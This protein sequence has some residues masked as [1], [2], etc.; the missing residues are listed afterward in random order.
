AGGS[1]RSPHTL[2]LPFVFATTG[3]AAGLVGEGPEQRLLERQMADAWVAFARTGD[4]NHAGMAPWTPYDMPGRLTMIL[5]SVSRTEPDP[6]ADERRVL[7]DC[8]PY[9]PRETEAYVPQLMV[10]SGTC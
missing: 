2:C 3:R 9:L 6:G 5:D 8:P 7:A 4:P 1:L 10:D